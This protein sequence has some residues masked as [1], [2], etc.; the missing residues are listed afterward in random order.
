MAGWEEEETPREMLS[1][2]YGEIF[3]NTYFAKHLLTTFPDFRW[4]SIFHNF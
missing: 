1:C 2:E 4:E 3:K